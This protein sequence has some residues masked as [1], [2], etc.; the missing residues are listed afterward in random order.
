MWRQNKKLSEEPAQGGGA[1]L[2]DRE[3]PESGHDLCLTDQLFDDDP[4][5]Q[6]QAI[7]PAQG[8]ASHL[9]VPEL[10]HRSDITSS[11]VSSSDL[12]QVEEI[13][14]VSASP[15]FSA[16][17][18]NPSPAYSEGA[19][20]TRSSPIFSD[21]F[22]L[23]EIE[24]DVSLIMVWHVYT[25]ITAPDKIN[26]SGACLEHKQLRSAKAWRLC[27]TASIEKMGVV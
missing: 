5:W 17:K 15:K 9:P 16:V 1:Q 14:T 8:D 3:S 23:P 19:R 26:L 18:N 10:E 4:F 20:R 13:Q 21:P 25:V 27:S 7:H 11:D 22:H 24:V 2:R 6:L 12:K